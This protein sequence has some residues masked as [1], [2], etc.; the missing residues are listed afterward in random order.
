MNSGTY[1]HARR[2]REGDIDSRI[3][4]PQAN[5][6]RSDRCALAE[7]VLLNNL[8]HA[9]FQWREAPPAPAYFRHL[10]RSEH[11]LSPEFAHLG[12]EIRKKRPPKSLTL[13]ILTGR[14]PLVSRHCGNLPKILTFRREKSPATRDRQPGNPPGSRTRPRKG[15]P[16]DPR[17]PH[18]ARFRAP[19]PEKLHLRSAFFPDTSHPKRCS[20]SI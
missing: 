1:P 6:V 14:P 20:P 2:T 15:S 11:Q 5:T 10:Q 16:L 3:T 13:S 18:F 12:R 8:T 4:S 17:S 19:A 9:G 7:S